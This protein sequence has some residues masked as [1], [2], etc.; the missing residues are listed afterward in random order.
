MKR[1]IRS[2][3]WLLSGAL[4]LIAA[5][6]AART[7]DLLT[8][9]ELTRLIPGLAP[10][11]ARGATSAPA[12]VIERERITVPAQGQH[13]GDTAVSRGSHAAPASAPPCGTPAGAS[14]PD[15]GIRLVGEY[16]Y[17]I[18]SA[19]VDAA[20]S[21]LDELSTQARVVP[22]F[23]DG[24]A[25]GFKMFAIRPDSLYARLGLQNGD[26]LQRIN[27]VSLNTPDNAVAVFESLRGARNVELDI[28]RRGTV[29]HMVYTVV[30]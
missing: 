19:E 6:V 30:R 8:D 15:D 5:P 27:G 22:A 28:D 21:R 1:F 17:V 4:L 13:L 18:P 23:R 3:F 9:F 16:S 11:R 14:T 12:I 7:L 24:Q 2:Y 10:E 26:V 20:F 25:R 29:V